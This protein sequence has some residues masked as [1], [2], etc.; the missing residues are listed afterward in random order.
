MNMKKLKER[1][2]TCK[3][4]LSIRCFSCDRIGHSSS[5]C[6]YASEDSYNEEDHINKVTKNIIYKEI[7]CSSHVSDRHE[8]LFITQ[9]YGEMKNYESEEDSETE[10]EVGHVEELIC[11]LGEIK[12]L[13]RKKLLPKEKL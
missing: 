7:N 3:G 6:I 1:D 10:G 8:A 9:D 11:A 2:G 5:K 12:K 13:R 4:N